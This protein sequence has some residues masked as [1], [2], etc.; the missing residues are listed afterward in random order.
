MRKQDSIF[1]DIVR[2]I[3]S[4]K[5]KEGI[6]GNSTYTTRSMHW[7][8]TGNS[9]RRASYQTMLKKNGFIKNVRRGLWE[10]TREI[11]D[12]FTVA[13]AETLLGYGI[14]YSKN[15]KTLVKSRTKMT[16]EEILEKLNAKTATVSKDS[17]QE[18]WGEL[19]P[20]MD[21]DSVSDLKAEM[22]R[23]RG[24]VKITKIT[25]KKTKSAQKSSAPTYTSQLH[26]NLTSNVNYIAIA[27]ENID[28]AELLDSVLYGR[29]I[30]IF[31]QVKD[32]HQEILNRINFEKTYKY[33]V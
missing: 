28:K 16:K 25:S 21:Q 19:A 22:L 3:N 18:E 20:W 11:P 17:P 24:N 13:H 7:N 32:L 10:V 33:E 5:K 6:E 1:N 29:L 31:V 30:N 12:W 4:V 27:L 8:V 15:G 14:W 9:Y 2:F 26:E 23:L